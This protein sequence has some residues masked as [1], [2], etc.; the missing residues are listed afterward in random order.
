[1]RIWRMLSLF[2]SAVS[3]SW[4]HIGIGAIGITIGAALV[5]SFIAL[6]MTAYLV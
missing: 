3:W 4:A 5:Y 6:L 1:M 2:S